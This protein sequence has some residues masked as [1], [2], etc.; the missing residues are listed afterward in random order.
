MSPEEKL[1]DQYL[2]L[3]EDRQLTDASKFLDPEILMVF[4]GNKKFTS[5]Q[6]MAQGAKGRYNWV[7]KRR[8]DFSTC[9][10][11]A[12]TV[13]TSRGTLYGEG[14]DGTPFADIRYIDYFVIRNEKIVEQHVWNDLAE[15]GI[16]QPN[17]EES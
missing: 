13:V 5:L 6:E 2:Q 11:G 15:L 9:D 1:V 14:V 8:T 17:S 16:T 7:K 4:P 10:T 12:D 3:C